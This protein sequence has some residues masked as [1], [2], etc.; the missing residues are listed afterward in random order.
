MGRQELV[1][2][3]LVSR[4]VGC[5]A[6]ISCLL[7]LACTTGSGGPDEDCNCPL[8]DGFAVRL[9]VVDGA[10][11][12]VLDGWDASAIVDDTDVPTNCSPAERATA[13]TDNECTFGGAQGYY[14]ISVRTEGRGQYEAVARV[15]NPVGVNCCVVGETRCSVSDTIVISLADP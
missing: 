5:A 11:N 8:C 12:S 14:R 7:A 10:G 6:M 3:G 1:L 4:V 13:G 2:S 15:Q 9:R